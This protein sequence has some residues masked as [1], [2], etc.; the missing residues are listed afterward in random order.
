MTTG[1]VFVGIDWGDNLHAISVIDDQGRFLERFKINHHPSEINPLPQKLAEIGDVQ[2]VCIETPNHLLVPVLLDAGFTVYDVNPKIT[3]RWQECRRANPSKT[4]QIDADSLADGLR[5]Y[6]KDLKP[7]SVQPSGLRLLRTLCA[8]E[9]TLIQDHTAL[10]LKLKSCLKSYFPGI[11]SWFK[12]WSRAS[13]LQFLI[14]YPMPKKLAQT[15]AST[16]QAFLAARKIGFTKEIWQK[17]I[18]NRK[19]VLE[20]RVDEALIEAKSLLAV[21]LAKQLLNLRAQLKAYRKKINEVFSAHESSQVFS[22]FPGAGEK[23]A[24][25]LLAAFGEN[26]EDFESANSLQCLAGVV[27]VQE[28]TGAKA[29]RGAGKGKGWQG[30]VRVHFRRAC[31]KDFRSTMHFFGLL[32]MKKSKWAKAFYKRARERGQSN[33]TALRNLGSKWL[34]IMY[35]CWL[36][37]ARYDE[38]QYVKS[39]KEHGSPLIDYMEKLELKSKGDDVD[40]TVEKNKLF[41]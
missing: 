38:A 36:N 23:L 28:Q 20:W 35:R 37:G 33:A 18:A 40:N 2:G 13:A 21:T 11:L 14:R 19:Q 7:L 29:K 5:L 32:S 24:P 25:R 9:I 15:R 31:R 26:H 17:R 41:T 8:D 1:K 22:S 3:K 6:Q 12:D 39:L 4:D 34:K 10:L 16:L 30:R 27:P